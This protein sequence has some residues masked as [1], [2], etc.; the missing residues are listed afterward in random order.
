MNVILYHMKINKVFSINAFIFS[1]LATLISGYVFYS[2]LE[3]KGTENE[4]KF[5]TSLI[6][7]SLFSV[8]FIILI[9]SMI[10]NRFYSNN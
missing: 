5:Y 2:N 10:L 1:L 7:F 6:G 8:L 9:I 4:W 3:M